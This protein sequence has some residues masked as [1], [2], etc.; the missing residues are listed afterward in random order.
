M[1]FSPLASFV[2]NIRQKT[3][4][5]FLGTLVTVWFISNWE[6]LYSVITFDSFVRQETKINV[7]KNYIISHHMMR[8]LI[9]CIIETVLVLVVT[10]FLLNVSRYIL[11]IYENRVTPWIYSKSKP[12][13]IIELHKYEQLI[14]E[15]D[16][17]VERYDKER[18]EKA[19]IQND[20]E[21]LSKGYHERELT[22]IQDN[23]NLKGENM[24]LN[25]KNIGLNNRISDL[26]NQ[27]LIKDGITKHYM[28]TIENLKSDIAKFDEEKLMS[29]FESK[30]ASDEKTA[31]ELI[32]QF[33]NKYYAE[34]F[35]EIVEKIG[36]H[37]SIPINGVLEDYLIK[38]AIIE[39]LDTLSD[40]KLYV[41]TNRGENLKQIFK[42]GKQLD[43]AV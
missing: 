38:Y 24:E 16:E 5:P 6:L 14:I 29:L 42:M 15:R 37:K 4:N 33:L 43:S 41:F 18:T 2:A 8:N 21:T 32:C 28:A 13:S 17:W 26:E 20:F 3:T 31:L 35:I 22:Y 1:D 19:R 39:V 10:Y 25:K 40:D 27:A 34:E 23:G 11:N 30:D 7:I 12:K 36:W 9:F